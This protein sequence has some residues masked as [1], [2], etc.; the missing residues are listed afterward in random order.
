MIITSIAQDRIV[1]EAPGT[2][3]STARRLVGGGPFHMWSHGTM[4]AKVAMGTGSVGRLRTG[5]IFAL[6]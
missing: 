6:S 2:G 5:P 1:S 3:T 4:V